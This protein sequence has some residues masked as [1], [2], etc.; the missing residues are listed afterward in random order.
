M[1]LV[2]EI[3]VAANYSAVSSLLEPLKTQV[4]NLSLSKD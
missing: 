3:L 1:T 4:V 2:L